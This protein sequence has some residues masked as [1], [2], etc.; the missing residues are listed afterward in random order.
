MAVAAWNG[1]I[2]PCVMDAAAEYR[3]S[4]RSPLRSSS[5]C[6]WVGRDAYL[7]NLLI[8]ATHTNVSFVF[9]GENNTHFSWY[10]EATDHGAG[11]LGER[12]N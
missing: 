11:L 2:E 4:G 7:M 10:N 1:C 6:P 9:Y 12:L 8:Q 3:A 5:K